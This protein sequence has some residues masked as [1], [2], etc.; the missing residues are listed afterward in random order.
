[1]SSST[2]LKYFD[3]S[4]SLTSQTKIYPS[5]PSFSCTPHAQHGKDGYCVHKLSMGTHTGTHVDAPYHFFAEGKKIDEIPLEQFIGEA[6]V[7]DLSG[8]IVSEDSAANAQQ[9]KLLQERE[10]ITWNDLEPFAQAVRPGS[11]VL[12]NTGWSEAHYR[13]PKYFNH[14]YFAPTVA[15]ELIARGVFLVGVD[16]LNPDETPSSQNEETEDGFGFHEAFL[17]AGGIIA[18]NLTNLEKLIEA[19]Q[20]S[21]Q[22][23]KWIASLVPLNLAGADGSPIRAFAYSV[24]G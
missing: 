15:S 4:H 9:R 23:E 5:D 19:Q 18:E 1:M 11:I 14:P 2:K 10:K 7:I 21:S 8:G 3:L 6:V 13:S 22:G 16:T 12:I 20:G 24:K 17:S